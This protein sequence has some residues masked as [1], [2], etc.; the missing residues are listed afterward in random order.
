MIPQKTMERAADLAMLGRTIAVI[1]KECQISMST[2]QKM[3]QAYI[4]AF[5]KNRWPIGPCQC[6]KKFGHKGR[7]LPVIRSCRRPTI[8]LSP[9]AMKLT[10]TPAPSPAGLTRRSAL[11][12]TR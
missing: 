12:M 4:R 10:S 2:A 7:C 3:R 5:R 1:S 11:N 9:L 8:S 6:G